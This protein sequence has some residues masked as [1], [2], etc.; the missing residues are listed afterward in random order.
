MVVKVIKVVIVVVVV[1][2]VI[3][4]VVVI[5]VDMLGLTRQ[6]DNLIT[7]QPETQQP[8]NPITLHSPF[9][10]THIYQIINQSIHS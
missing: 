9:H 6:P 2:V 8:D 10:L 3:V 4:I 7:R 1:K 5:V